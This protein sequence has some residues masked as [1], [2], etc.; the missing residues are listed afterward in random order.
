MNHG[1]K[2]NPYFELDQFHN[3]EVMLRLLY[4]SLDKIRYSFLTMS[5]HALPFFSKF[6]NFSS[7]LLNPYKPDFLN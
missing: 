3:Y 5:V 7:L 6:I 2:L 1:I 4:E